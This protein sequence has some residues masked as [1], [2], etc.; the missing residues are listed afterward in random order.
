MVITHYLVK[1]VQNKIIQNLG[2]IVNKE[3]ICLEGCHVLFSFLAY[4]KDSKEVQMIIIIRPLLHS[5]T[6]LLELLTL[7]LSIQ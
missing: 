4:T 6:W 1:N 5:N 7:G 2:S 3:I